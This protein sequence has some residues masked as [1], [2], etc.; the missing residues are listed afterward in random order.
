ML[1]RTA[2]ARQNQGKRDSDQGR[3]SQSAGQVLLGR[4]GLGYI[5]RRGIDAGTSLALLTLDGV[6]RMA[7]MQPLTMLSLLPDIV[8]EV[9]LAAWNGLRLGCGPEVVRL[10]AMTVQDGG[11]GEEDPAGTAAIDALFASLPDEVGDFPS[12]LAR[13]FLMTMFSGMAAVEAVPG[14]SGTGL[15]EL[16][17]VN[18]LTLRFKRED[19][20][21]LGLYQ[22]QTADPNGLA[23]YA[24]GMGGV[25]TPMPMDRFF[26]ASLDGFP[27]DPYG[28]APFAPAINEVLICLAYIRDLTLAVHRIGA[29]RWDV[30]FDFEMWAT[31]ARDVIGLT[32]PAEIDE[33]V[34]AKFAESVQFFNDL[35]ADDAFFHDLKTTVNAVGAGDGWPDVT[36]IWELLRLRLVQALKQMPTLMGVHVGSTETYSG[37]EWQIYAKGLEA[38]VAKAA[39]PLVKAAQLHLQLLGMP[40]R[41]EAE[42]SPIRANQ[43]MSDA[44]AEQLEIANAARKRDEGWTTQ[45]EAAMAIT[46]TAAVAEPRNWQTQPQVQEKLTEEE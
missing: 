17:P 44:Q 5:A 20:G 10:K 16:W 34:Q 38:I 7:T 43:R 27:D 33:W 36:G 41:V 11:K 12:A 9:G 25:Y 22:R 14:P 42:F 19:D 35:K 45:D 24:A 6:S 26:W 4:G 8:P 21:S 2:A 1:N 37:V 32:D 46:G 23:S 15:K 18:S 3:V 28:R 31:L 40:L 13:N 30:G 39:W 29:P